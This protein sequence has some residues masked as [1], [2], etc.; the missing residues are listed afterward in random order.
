[1]FRSWTKLTKPNLS[2]SGF[3]YNAKL[4]LRQADKSIFW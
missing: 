4:T 3:P 2:E 1:M